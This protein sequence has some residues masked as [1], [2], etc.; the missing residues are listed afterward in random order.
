MEAV[1]DKP[2]AAP[3]GRPRW[4]K[5]LVRVGL[6]LPLVG[7]AMW[8]AVHHIPGFGPLVADSLRWAFGNEFVA[9]LEDTAYGAEDWMNR[10][11]RADAPAEPMWQ[12]PETPPSSIPPP[13]SAT[14]APPPPPFALASLAPMHSEVAAKGEGVWV[15]VV[16]PR[17][18]GDRTRLLKT[19]LHPDK[20]RS[21][22]VVAVVAVDLSS[23]ELHAVAGRFEPERK[24]K[25]AKAYKTPAVVPED[26]RERLI[27]AFNGGYKSTHGEYGMKV[28]GVELA[29]P[30]TRCCVVARMNDGSYL[31]RDWE[32]VKEREAEMSWW[33]QTPICM[34][35]E[36]APHPMLAM[37]KFGWG[38]AS[39]S[40]TTVIR[41]SAIGLDK[42]RKLMFIGIG[43]HVTGQAIGMAMHHAG[44]H[45]VSQLDVNFSFPKF[46][47]YEHKAPGSAELKAVPLTENFEYT[48]DQYVG[49]EAERDFFYLARR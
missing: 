33:R 16:D 3:P 4:R 44:A 49:K 39:V 45:Y 30:R 46:V 13:P 36:G 22:S 35:D 8:L 37:P 11:T 23:V 28:G 6:A 25:D 41:R 20:N 24:S 18:P 5:W 38:A 1:Q 9:W 47:L 32:K 2:A 34:F 21:W 14:G 17:Q 27:A 48:E 42:E 31:I 40:G 15:P 43:D 7:V 29:P 19:F 26:M 10:K 12:V